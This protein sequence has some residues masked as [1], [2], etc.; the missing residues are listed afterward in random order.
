M[1]L[2]LILLFAMVNTNLWSTLIAYDG[3]WFHKF[4]AWDRWTRYFWARDHA[5]LSF[6]HGDTLFQLKDPLFFES[7]L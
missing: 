2:M 5:L 6:E 7:S 3:H 1:V 4:W